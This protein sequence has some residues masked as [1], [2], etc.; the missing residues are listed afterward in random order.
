MGQADSRSLE[1]PADVPPQWQS[2]SCP[3]GIT[4]FLDSGSFPLACPAL[5]SVYCQHEEH[6]LVLS[7]KL[8]L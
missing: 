7:L 8:T 5:L 2:P 1:L 6:N 4:T 3:R